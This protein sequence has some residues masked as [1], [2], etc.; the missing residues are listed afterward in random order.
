MW[1][2]EPGA[3]GRRA[4]YRKPAR[5]RPA[6]RHGIAAI[7]GTY[8]DEQ[9]SL[10][11]RLY[12]WRPTSHSSR[13]PTAKADLITGAIGEDSNFHQLRGYYAPRGAIDTGM[14]QAHPVVAIRRYV[15]RGLAHSSRAQGSYPST[16]RFG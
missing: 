11:P 4:T 1:T 10:K 7:L 6:H 3:V 8:E 5:R 9:L 13:T 14:D 15:T 2:D 12:R 16:R